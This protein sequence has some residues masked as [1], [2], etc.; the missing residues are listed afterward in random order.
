MIL[1]NDFKECSSGM[2]ERFLSLY[3]VRYLVYR[4]YIHAK[5]KSAFSIFRTNVNFNNAH[6]DFIYS[7]PPDAAQMHLISFFSI[8][9]ILAFLVLK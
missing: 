4:I 8:L 1:G 2:R 3:Y 7:F 9:H 5:K 6:T